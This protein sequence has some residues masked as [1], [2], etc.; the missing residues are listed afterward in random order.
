MTLAI[1]KTRGAA[2]YCSLVRLLF[3]GSFPPRQQTSILSLNSTQT[4]S[5]LL[6]NP[7][8]M[9]LERLPAELRLEIIR[10]LSTPNLKALRH[11]N[12]E[13]KDNTTPALFG[14]A[15]VAPRYQA[16]ATFQ[17]I[18]L[19]PSLSAHVKEV[20]FDGSV[21]DGF[22]AE[23]EAFYLHHNAVLPGLQRGST[24]EKHDRSVVAPLS[25]LAPTQPDLLIGG[26]VTDSCSTSKTICRATRPC[27]TRLHAL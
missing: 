22:I 12:T 6:A 9:S 4:A 20:V 19:A 5:L 16:L 8:G 24:L 2:Q 18:S 23:R 11:V 13:L 21:Y 10:Y 25:I 3:L 15:V 14:R 17:N 27:W 1:G 26:Y 7:S